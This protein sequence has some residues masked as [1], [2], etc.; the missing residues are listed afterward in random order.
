MRDCLARQSQDAIQEHVRGGVPLNRRMGDG[1]F[2]GQW[3]LCGIN[4][5]PQGVQRDDAMVR[6]F[7]G[8]VG[9]MGQRYPTSVK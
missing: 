6:G 4:W 8:E 5:Q 3:S 9:N 1:S 2:G 7:G